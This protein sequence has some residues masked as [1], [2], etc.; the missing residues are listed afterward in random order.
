MVGS[1]I[2]RLEG[3]VVG[4]LKG[5]A[6]GFLVSKS[7]GLNMRTIIFEG[8]DIAFIVHVRGEVFLVGIDVGFVF[9][10]S[11]EGIEIPGAV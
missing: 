3:T 6:V 10:G 2:G 7:I 11:N 4:M 1:N 9:F 8:F 5:I